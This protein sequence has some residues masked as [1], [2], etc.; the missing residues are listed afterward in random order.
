MVNTLAYFSHQ[1]HH[2]VKFKKTKGH[3][4]DPRN[5]AYLEQHL[6]LRGEAR[7]NNRADELADDARAHF[8]HPN[9]RKLSSLLVT[10]HDKYIQFVHA[11][12]LIIRRVYIV[13]QEIRRAQALVGIHPERPLPRSIVFIPT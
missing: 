5:R 1:R 4:L 9:M 2:G 10:R 12:V 7:H 8:F 3:A 11:I 13:S 6:E